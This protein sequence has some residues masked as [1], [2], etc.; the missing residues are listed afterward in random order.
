MWKDAVMSQ[1]EIVS[2]QSG[3]EP[4]TSRTRGRVESTRLQSDMDLKR[5]TSLLRKPSY[6]YTPYWCVSAPPAPCMFQNCFP[7]SQGW[8][9]NLTCSSARRHSISLPRRFFEN[10]RRARHSPRSFLAY[11]PNFEGTKVSLCYRHAVCIPLPINFW[12]P[13]PV[14]V[15]FDIDIMASE[16]ISTAY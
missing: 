8:R 9:R 2:G 11:F 15:K 6:W 10:K 14:F 4:G 3:F 1:C 13:E 7:H 16:P 12:M 5:R